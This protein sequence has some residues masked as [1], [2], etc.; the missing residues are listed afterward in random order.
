MGSQMFWGGKK[1]PQRLTGPRSHMRAGA[2]HIAK[3][4]KGLRAPGLGGVL[5]SEEG[6]D[7]GPD[8]RREPSQSLRF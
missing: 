3:N 1:T 8:V 7:R 2:L 5:G 6:D 4:Q